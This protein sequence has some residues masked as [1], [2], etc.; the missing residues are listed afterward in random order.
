M[1]KTNILLISHSKKLADGL[2]DIIVQMAPNVNIRA[3]GGTEDGEIGSDFDKI[4]KSINQL[5]ENDN[6]VIF[7]D[8][9]SSMMNAQM[10]IELLEEQR[11]DRVILADNAMIESAVQVSIMAE[12]DEGIEEI[13]K[14]LDS[15]KY[16]KID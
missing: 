9:G 14:Y 6:L 16:H 7:F 1:M 13:K 8:L 2:K 3:V 15:H 5:S 11:R 10:A 12:A 4:N